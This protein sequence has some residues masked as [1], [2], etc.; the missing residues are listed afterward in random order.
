MSHLGQI[1][2]YQP[3][4]LEIAET[5]ETVDVADVAIVDVAEV[6]AVKK[7]RQIVEIMEIVGVVGVVVIVD[8]AALIYVRK[9]LNVQILKI[10]F[11]LYAGLSVATNQ[12]HQSIQIIGVQGTPRDSTQLLK[13]T[14]AM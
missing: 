12:I 4:A 2:L 1:H 7:I 14:K 10:L 11:G 9:F 13:V 8:V 3:G 6:V 5:V